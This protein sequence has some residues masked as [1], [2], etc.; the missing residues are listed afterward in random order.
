[1]ST[2]LFIITLRKSLLP[3]SIFFVTNYFFFHIFIGTAVYIYARSARKLQGIVIS[4]ANVT[5]R[6]FKERARYLLAPLINCRPFDR[7]RLITHW[8]VM[9]SR[10]DSK[11]RV[12]LERFSNS[13]KS[14]FG[15]VELGIHN[16][17]KRNIN[18]SS[19]YSES[20]NI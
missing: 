2:I 14:F 6:L 15:N 13:W 1:M 7:V 12:Y 3:R 10:A 11:S 20:M 8:H 5:R 18:R 9:K 19:V 16:H 17:S 4:G